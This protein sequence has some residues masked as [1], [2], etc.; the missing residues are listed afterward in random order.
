[1]FNM[2]Y[3]TIKFASIKEIKEHSEIIYICVNN[4]YYIYNYSGTSGT[5]DLEYIYKLQ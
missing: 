2:L 3:S 5:N 4:S 1:M